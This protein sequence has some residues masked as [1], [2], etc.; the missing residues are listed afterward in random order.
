MGEEKNSKAITILTICISA[1][2]LILSVITFYFQFFHIEHSISY[3]A[4]QIGC[5]ENDKEIIVPLLFKNTGNQQDVILNATLYLELKTDTTSSYRR[6]SEFKA[7]GFP[8]MLAPSE[9]TLYQL[10]GKYKDY[11]IGQFVVSND[12]ITGYI[13]VKYLDKL[14][15][16][17]EIE[18]ITSEGGYAK[19]K[20]LL[21]Y[22]FFNEDRTIKQI[23]CLPVELE[24]LDMTPDEVYQEYYV[25]PNHTAKTSI[26]FNINDSI[27][28][29]E[30]QD[31]LH[32]MRE[33]LR[34][35]LK[36]VSRKE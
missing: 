30:N 27:A 11:F 12:E 8:M 19:E 31:Y 2:A 32:L 1:I 21:G 26:Q 13:P 9:N 34:D 28:L 22:V 20:R 35:S 15:L 17:L 16:I 24:S 14:E 3:T 23:S 7:D 36:N 25:L 4:T 29:K 18:Y 33:L 5:N 6:I 10:V